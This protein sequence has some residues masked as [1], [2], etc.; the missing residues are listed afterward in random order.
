M[1]KVID[2]LD[3]VPVLNIFSCLWNWAD[4]EEYIV[5]DDK[6]VLPEEL[7]ESDRKTDA[8]YDEHF[9]PATKGKAQFRVKEEQL[10]KE[11]AKAPET[12]KE[13]VIEEKSTDERSRWTEFEKK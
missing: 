13:Q 6:T 4:G 10:N 3:K 11:V 5:D 8:S 12:Q 7:A 2:K 9:K 1:A